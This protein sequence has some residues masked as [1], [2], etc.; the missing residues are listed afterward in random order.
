MVKASATSYD[1]IYNLNEI[2]ENLEDERYSDLKKF[3]K[4]FYNAV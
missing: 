2:I 4:T 3:F 1:K